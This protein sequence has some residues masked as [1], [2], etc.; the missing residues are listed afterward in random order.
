M[1]LESSQL[2]YHTAFSHLKLVNLV[3]PVPQILQVPLKLALILGALLA[4]TDSLVHTRGTANEDLNLLALLWLRQHSL[5]Q[6]L[7]N[8]SLPA[9]PLLRRVIQDVEGAEALGVRV[10]EVLELALQQDILLG[11]AAV[12]KRDLRLVLRVLEDGARRLPHRGDARATRDQGDVLVLVG[13]PLVLG[14]G[15]LDVQPLPGLEVVHVRGHGAVGVRLD[16]EVDG[17]L[18]VDVADGRVGADHGLLHLGALVLG[19]DGR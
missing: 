1:I 3:L 14:D 8:M 2:I 12:D 5:K 15:A 6:L 4:T 18:L 13:G 9:L 19:D 17:A 7:S 16:E 10:L 11:D